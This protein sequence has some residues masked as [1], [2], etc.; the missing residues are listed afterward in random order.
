MCSLKG[1]GYSLA[2]KGDMNCAYKKIKN[3][4][5]WYRVCHIFNAGSHRLWLG[6]RR[7]YTHA[8]CG[9]DLHRGF[10]NTIRPTGDTAGFNAANGNTLPDPVPHIGFTANSTGQLAIWKSNNFIR[11]RRLG[12]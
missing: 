5:P 3:Q 7:G 9:R 1:D 12:L 10:S 2:Q 6:K 8:Q 4:T 11:D